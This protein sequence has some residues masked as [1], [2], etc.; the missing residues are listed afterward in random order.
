MKREVA[1]IGAGDVGS[2]LAR[3]LADAGIGTVLVDVSAA[4]EVGLDRAAQTG[5]LYLLPKALFRR[6]AAPLKKVTQDPAWE[7]AFAPFYA[8]V[9][10]LAARLPPRGDRSELPALVLIDAVLRLIPGAIGDAESALED[11][12]QNGL[13]DCAWYTRPR[14]FEGLTVPD[15]LLGGD[16]AKIVAWRRK[17]ALART[18]AKRPDL[19]DNNPTLD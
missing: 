17:N 12:F 10:D 8:Q 11:S 19:L 18:C 15:V 16:H 4:I 13:L 5:D 1:I 2:P 6:L 7:E 9:L 14:E 3:V